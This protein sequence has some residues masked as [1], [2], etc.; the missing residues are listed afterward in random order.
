MM[1][2]L[3]TKPSILLFGP[4]T[5]ILPSRSSSASPSRAAAAK[6]GHRP[7]RGQRGLALT[8]ASTAAADRVT[9]GCPFQ[10]VERAV[11]WIS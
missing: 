9:P 8:G 4:G 11:S 6:V 10:T 2:P 3:R 7:P 1:P 5:A